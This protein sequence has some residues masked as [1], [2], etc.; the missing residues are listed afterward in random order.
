MRVS[1]AAGI[2][3][4]MLTA[5]LGLGGCDTSL[6][7]RIELY[8]GVRNAGVVYV[9]GAGG[10][11]ANPGTPEQPKKTIQN[12]IDLADALMDSGEVRV[13]EGLY[14]VRETVVVRK[15]I[16]ILGGYELPGWTRNLDLQSEPA[17]VIRGDA[18][19]T[20]IRPETG[21]TPE[22]LVELFAIEASSEVSATCIWCDHGSPTVRFNVLDSSGGIQYSVGI[23][24]QYGEPVI[25]SNTINAG[26]GTEKARGILNE[27]SSPRIWNNVIY[28]TGDN[29]TFVAISNNSGSHAIIQNNTIRIGTTSGGIGIFNSDSN[30]VIENNIIFSESTAGTCIDEYG[31]T[32]LPARVKN[33]DFYDCSKIYRHD[34]GSFGNVALMESYLAGSPNNVE[35][36][37]N[38]SDDPG[39]QYNTALDWHLQSGSSVAEA[40]LDLG[41]YF[42]YD[43][44]NNT[45]I[46]PWSIGAYE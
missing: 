46:P 1:A 18:I 44:E 8:V 36:S 30:C 13:A 7:D 40:G 28:G 35:A 37:G 2:A 42:T 20:V 9:D 17:T 4:V 31:G 25:V 22:T 26:M 12:A 24:N 19:D 39:F 34:G 6:R 16:S 3:A 38:R 45:R 41:V 29:G 27:G 14:V 33:N 43:R 5:T 23:F 10:D 15:G 32:A 11:D 21:V